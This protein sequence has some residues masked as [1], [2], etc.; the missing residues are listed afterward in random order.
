[1]A[2]G[3]RVMGMVAAVVLAMAGA[4]GGCASDPAPKARCR[5]PWVLIEGAPE[6]VPRLSSATRFGSARESVPARQRAA[7]RPAEPEEIVP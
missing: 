2:P 3:W 5:G 6:S 7:A 1:M 4:L